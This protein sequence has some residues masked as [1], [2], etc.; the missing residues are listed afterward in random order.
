MVEVAL[1]AQAWEAEDS[2]SGQDDVEIHAVDT[3]QAA[4]HK[5]YREIH[6]QVGQE[7]R[8]ESPQDHQDPLVQIADE[9]GEVD[10]DKAA[11]GMEGAAAAEALRSVSL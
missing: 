10:R 1:G 8:E 11:A 7:D 3:S 2:G 6:S 9:D 4:L 5:V